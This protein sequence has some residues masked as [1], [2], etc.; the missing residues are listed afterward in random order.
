MISE[1]H[2]NYHIQLIQ[3]ASEIITLYENQHISLRNAMKNYSEFSNSDD[4]QS[5]SQVHALVFETVRFQNIFNRLIHGEIQ[6]TLQEKIPRKIRNTLRVITYLLTFAPEA[7]KGAVW[8]EA[9]RKIL[10]SFEDHQTGV[11]GKYPEY[12]EKWTLNTLLESIDDEEERIAVQYAHPTWLVRELIKFYGLKTTLKILNSNNDTLP[13]YLRLN[14][15]DYRKN[16]ILDQL[17]QEGVIFELDPELN[18]VVKVISTKLPIPRLTSYKKGLYYMQTKGSSIISHILDPKEGELILDACAAPGGKTTHIATLQRDKGFIVGTD[19]NKRRM[20]ELKRKL[21]VYNLKSIH[22]ILYDLRFN[23]PFKVKFDKILLDVPCSGTGTFSS[24]PDTKWRI[25]RHHVKWIHRLQLTLLKNTS[26]FLKESKDSALIYSTCSL[27]PMENE[28]VIEKF[29]FSNPEFELKPQ[30][31]FIGTPSP[32]FSL[33]Q[34]LF[35]HINQTDGFSI[36][37]LGYKES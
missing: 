24:R 12:L 17:S 4:M 20:K 1:K 23:D 7:Q 31:Y 18:D 9:C 3:I 25:D 19:N 37:K 13:V 34:R 10:D 21:R 32:R 5:Y 14:L 28:D 29:L 35:P 33:G 15:L 26:T 8:N 36:F 22:P 27:L 16:K 2:L 30:K 6:S 11:Y